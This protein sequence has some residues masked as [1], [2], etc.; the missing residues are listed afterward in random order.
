VHLGTEHGLTRLFDQNTK[1]L[2]LM[3][4]Y[5]DPYG[6]STLIVKNVHN[7][8]SKIHSFSAQPTHLRVWL[9]QVM[10]AKNKS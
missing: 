9:A 3:K 6:L 8:M 1:V 5:R 10:Y 7:H 2:K 4:K